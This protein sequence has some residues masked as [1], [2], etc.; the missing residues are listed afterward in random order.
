MADLRLAR[1]RLMSPAFYSAAMDCFGP[2]LIKQGR[3][4][5]K[6]WAIIYKCLTTRCVHLD[7]LQSMDTDSFLMSL[8]RFTEQRATPYE[9]LSDQGTNFRRGESELRGVLTDSGS[10]HAWLYLHLSSWPHE[11]DVVPHFCPEF[12]WDIL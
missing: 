9:L 10:H 5:E 7:T 11:A 4:T 3:G 2:F 1:L 8:K 12:F 6:T